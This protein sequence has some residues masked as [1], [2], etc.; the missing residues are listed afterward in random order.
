MCENIALIKE[1][2]E[3]MS[4]ANATSLAVEILR[5]INLAKLSDRYVSTCSVEEIFLVMFLRAM[6]CQEKNVILK[7]PSA[8]LGNLFNIKQLVQ[9]IN[10]VNKSKKIIILDLMS[11]ELSYKGCECNIEKLN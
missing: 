2:H 11:D 1:V 5:E 6:M 8:I 10:R 9:N 7:L 4:I 3:N